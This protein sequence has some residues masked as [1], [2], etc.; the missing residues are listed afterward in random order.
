MPTLKFK[1]KKKTTRKIQ[2]GG[3]FLIEL[4]KNYLILIY[5]IHLFKLKL[6]LI[7]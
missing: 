1:H 5:Q 7:H 2:R 4:K 6:I 3:G